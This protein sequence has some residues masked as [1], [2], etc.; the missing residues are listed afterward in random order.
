LP[1]ARPAEA[2]ADARLADLLDPA[3]LDVYRELWPFGEGNPRPV[4]RLRDVALTEVLDDRGTSRR[5]RVVD[6][7]AETT[8]TFWKSER[9][10]EVPARIDLTC[11]LDLF[12]YRGAEVAGLTAVDA[13]PVGG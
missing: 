11:R 4:F 5:V 7:A 2:D 8:L 6:G 3:F 10:P 9:A 13:T 1:A 12:E